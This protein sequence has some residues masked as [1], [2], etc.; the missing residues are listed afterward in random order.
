MVRALMERLWTERSSPFGFEAPPAPAPE[1]FFV[2]G[3]L[4]R[5]HF[6]RETQKEFRVLKVP[7]GEGADFFVCNTRAVPAFSP[8]SHATIFA[9]GEG[10]CFIGSN[11]IS[12]SQGAQTLIREHAGAVDS[13]AL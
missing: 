11:P 7:G 2:S 6:L 13:P 8:G 10:V 4:R 3:P 1:G 9:G 5:F 12:A